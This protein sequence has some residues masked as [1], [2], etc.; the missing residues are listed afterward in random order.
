MVDPV[1]WNKRTGRVVGGHQ[2]LK[3]LREIRVTRHFSG[4]RL[5]HNQAVY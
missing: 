1:V 3:V 4:Q 5:Y 2:R